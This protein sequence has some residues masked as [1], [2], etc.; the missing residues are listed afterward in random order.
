MYLHGISELE[1]AIFK[2]N[3][4][5]SIHFR[6]RVT[7]ASPLRLLFLSSMTSFRYISLTG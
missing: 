1:K 6:D 3:D 4:Q 2:F 7:V 5:F